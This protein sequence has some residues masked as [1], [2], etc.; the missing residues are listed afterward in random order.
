MTGRVLHTGTGAY[1]AYGLALAVL[2]L[3]GFVSLFLGAVSIDPADVVRA[4]FLPS[5]ASL[6]DATIIWSVRLPR[7]LM[8]VLAGA[9]L[10]IS[11]AV[12]QGL[13]RNPLADPGITGVS[14][15]AALAAVATIVIGQNLFGSDAMRALPV[16]AF[17]G[18]LAVTGVLH[19]IATRNGRTSVTMM[20][21]G[22]IA[23][24]AL[25][26]ALTG[27]LI[28]ISSEQQLRELTFWTM[29]SLAGASWWRVGSIGIALLLSCLALPS[30][31][32]T[33]DRMSLGE[34]EAQ[35]MGVNVERS[36]LLAII[37]TALLT[38]AAVAASGI[39]GFVGLIVPHLLRISIGP[40]HRVLI[41][42]SAAG[43][44]L[45][46]LIADQFARTLAAPAELPI[47]IVTASIGGPVFLW[48]LLK[49]APDEL[50]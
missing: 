39:I 23:L 17:L 24:G 41:P 15:G 8:A 16:T 13:F 26:T 11:G 47:G 18:G 34:A 43:G 20:L 44:A 36:K 5:E 9:C 29:G 1:A 4:L 27:L 33:L 31:M 14:A 7:T 37:T 28:F 35:Y 42:L 12:M 22:G 45:L 21:L 6:R 48:L 25:A 49:S 3:A 40:S 19:A 2:G 50:H 30:L 10:G 46:M 32:K 38:G